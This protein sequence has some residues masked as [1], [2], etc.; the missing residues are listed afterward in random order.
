[1]TPALLGTMISILEKHHDILR[2]SI[3]GEKGAWQQMIPDCLKIP[4]TWVDL[5]NIDIEG[6]SRYIEQIAH[7]LHITLNP[8]S[9]SLVR[10]VFFARGTTVPG[11]LLFIIHHIIT[12]GFSQS[13]LYDDLET[14][15][16]QIK[17]GQE[18]ALPGKTSSFKVWSERVIKYVREELELKQDWLAYYQT[19]PWHE[20]KPL[21]ADSPERDSAL[22]AHTEHQLTVV[23]GREEF[24]LLRKWLPHLKLQLIEVL[25]TALVEAFNQW[26]GLPILYI[27]LTDSGR[28]L[29]P[30]L[31][32]S[33]T[34]G[35][36]SLSRWYFLDLRGCSQRE[37]RLVAT[38]Q[39]M[40]S[41]PNKGFDLELAYNY[42]EDADIQEQLKHFL[43]FQ[44]R[45]NFLSVGFN[46]MHLIQRDRFFCRASGNVQAPMDTHL[47]KHFEL[48][49]LGVL[50]PEG[51]YL[52]WS[53]DE[54]VY[55][56]Q[57]IEKLAQYYIA[58]L[59]AFAREA[60][61]L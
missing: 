36:F 26:T 45:F 1:M 44:I 8:F 51:F 33:R 9:D 30:S 5:S 27:M 12:D 15:Y 39:Q 17:T 20:L 58:S 40:R 49:C 13:I 60:A 42:I 31:D 52:K 21:P 7:D 25:L 43:H 29:F 3:T 4:I 28:F 61:V 34:V 46:S 19:L 2:L 59:Q 38:R 50:L 37:D 53:F 35:P 55:R 47:R 24:N 56:Y 10:V 54:K 11:Q 22:I 32:V 16:K 23:L 48:D 6:H 14:I 41:T 18:V 57:T